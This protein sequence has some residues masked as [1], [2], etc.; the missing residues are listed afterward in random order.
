MFGGA[1]AHRVGK[2]GG[3]VVEANRDV[4]HLDAAA[5]GGAFETEIEPA[6]A[7]D[8]DFPADGFIAAQFRDGAGG[9]RFGH[10]PVRVHRVDADPAP[11][12]LNHCPGECEL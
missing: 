6:V 1:L 9:D 10:Q 4:F 5:A 3:A 8:F 12:D 2:G 11:V 7:A